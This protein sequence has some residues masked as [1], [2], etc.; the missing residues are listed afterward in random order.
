MTDDELRALDDEA[1]DEAIERADKARL[2]WR[3]DRRRPFREDAIARWEQARLDAAAALRQQCLDGLRAVSAGG[4]IGALRGAADLAAVA[5][6]EHLDAT[7]RS[8]IL[9]A[10][11]SS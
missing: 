2:E 7:M 1:L 5:F 11:G 10:E 4:A 9:G 6:D 8:V 3:A